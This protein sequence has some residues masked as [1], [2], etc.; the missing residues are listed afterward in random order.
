VLLTG[1]SIY[2]IGLLL[3]M[4]IGN[5]TT[6]CI[7][8]L[9]LRATSAPNQVM[10]ELFQ[11]DFCA[12]QRARAL[13]VS[14]FKLLGASPSRSVD[15]A[16]GARA[17]P[18]EQAM[19]ATFDLADGAQRLYAR[20]AVRYQ[21]ARVAANTR[22]LQRVR[23]VASKNAAAIAEVEARV[24]EASDSRD[25]ANL[26]AA[27]ASVEPVEVSPD[28]AIV[29]GLVLDKAAH[30]RAGLAVRAVDRAGRPVA[31][32]KTDDNGYFRLDLAPDT[33]QPP[34]GG[35]TE[36]RIITDRYAHAD[37]DTI[38]DSAPAPA[39]GAAQH[40]AGT[41]GAGGATTGAGG[42]ATGGGRTAP[43]VLEVADGERV[44]FRDKQPLTASVGKHR[45]REIRIE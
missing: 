35:G 28:I 8:A 17:D 19:T 12:N 6:R 10:M 36:T 26:G 14:R 22:E 21:T 39:T 4:T 18:T 15:T 25:T 34:A 27:R 1:L 37:A 30:T 44:V 5:Q 43:I 3:N 33:S 24:A 2:S 9:G 13:G 40:P 7:N 41:T 32:T 31:A 23:T 29:H 11:P 20:D 42:A 38:R 16:A 45:Y